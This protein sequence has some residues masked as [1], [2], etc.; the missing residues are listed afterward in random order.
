MSEKTEEWAQ[1]VTY[2]IYIWL[3]LGCE[4]PIDKIGE[5]IPYEDKSSPSFVPIGAMFS[6]WRQLILAAA[7]G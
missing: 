6:D 5:L 1:K 3:I 2:L 4:S 7:S